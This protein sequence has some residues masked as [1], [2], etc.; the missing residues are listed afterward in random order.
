MLYNTQFFDEFNK[1]SN[2]NSKNINGM[3]ALHIAALNHNV[4]AIKN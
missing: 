2:F 3:T 1:G 4:S